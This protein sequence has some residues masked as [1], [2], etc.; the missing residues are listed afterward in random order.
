MTG[1]LFHPFASPA[2]TDWIDV[3]RGDGALIWDSN[4]KEY[5]DATASLWYCNAGHGRHEIVDA[6]TAQMRE[7]EAYHLFDPFTNPV[8]DAVA[9]RIAGITPVERARVFLCSSGSE[10]VDSAMKLARLAQVRAGHPERTVI[11]SRQRGYHGTNYGGTSAQGLPPNKEGYG[12]L[13]AEVI[14]VDADDSESLSR[15]MLD[16]EG[17]VAAV[18]TEPVQGAAGVYPPLPGYLEETRRLCDQHG[19]FLVFDEVITGFGRLGP[20]FAADHFGVLPDLT[21][22]AKG[23]TSGYQPLGGV[24]L[25]PTVHEPLASDPAFVLRHGYTY[26]GHP[27]ACAAGL[28]NI[29]ILEGLL[30]EAERIGTQ[31]RDGFEALRDDGAVEEVR[32][33]GAMFGLRIE[34][35]RTPADVRD[36]LHD[37][38]V[39]ARPIGTDT[40]TFSPPL[41]ITDEQVG[42]VVD[43]VA[44][45]LAD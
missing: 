18:L 38:G 34:G 22:F 6:V 1:A 12:E 20:W 37:R 31:M 44:E 23:V 15:A 39:I 8:A 5:I 45:A 28:A 4:G 2:R 3:V 24:I 40:L 33:I 7:L 32:G 17:R 36:R 41:V 25:A 27:A 35:N 21:T 10:A 11:I 16:H 19:A 14:Q 29:D 43:A 26:S 30:G 9:E 42:R 13:L